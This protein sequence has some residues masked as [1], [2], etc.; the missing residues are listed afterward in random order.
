MSCL[1]ELIAAKGAL[2]VIAN[3]VAARRRA[4]VAQRDALDTDILRI[5]RENPAQAARERRELADTILRL[6]ELDQFGNVLRVLGID[7]RPDIQAKGGA[8]A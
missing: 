2:K 7:T 1:G 6:D 4:L 8:A 3:S 5:R